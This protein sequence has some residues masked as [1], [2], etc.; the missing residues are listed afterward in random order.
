[1]ISN[2]NLFG[3]TVRSY[4]KD[5]E[6]WSRLRAKRAAEDHWTREQVCLKFMPLLAFLHLPCYALTV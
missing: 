6:T 3:K 4:S 2:S 5:R 1:M